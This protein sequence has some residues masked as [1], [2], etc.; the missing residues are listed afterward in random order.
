MPIPQSRVVDGGE[1]RTTLD[2]RGDLFPVFLFEYR[3]GDVNET[4]AGPDIGAG[5][6]ED[7]RLFGRAHIELPLGQPPLGVRATAPGAAAG[8]RRVDKH[9]IHVAAQS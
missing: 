7:R 4:A 8:T 3:T 9:Q 6:I 1:I 5:G 2:E